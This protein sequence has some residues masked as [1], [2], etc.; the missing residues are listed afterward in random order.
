MSFW[1][2]VTYLLSQLD[3]LKLA[4]HP[5]RKHECDQERRDRG[6]N[7]AKA[8]V[9]K[10]IQKRELC[11]ERIEPDIQHSLGDRYEA[12]FVVRVAPRSASATSSNFIPREALINTASPGL[13]TVSMAAAAVRASGA[14]IIWDGS[15]PACF[16]PLARL[17]PNT[18]QATSRST[19][20]RAKNLPTSSCI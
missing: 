20:W 6:V 2:V 8:L 19:P 11:M 18:P 16:A 5:R 7:N 10:N 1:S 14:S 12:F 3:F 13:T 17:R 9:T 15:S 4:D